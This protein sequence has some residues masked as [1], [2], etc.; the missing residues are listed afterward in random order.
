MHCN[1]LVKII[2]FEVQKEFYR[3][4]KEDYDLRMDCLS[5]GLIMSL[6]EIIELYA[7]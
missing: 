6:F 1:R 5:E 4:V 2:W 7:T 3:A